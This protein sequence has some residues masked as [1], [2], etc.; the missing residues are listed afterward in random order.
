MLPVAF[1]FITG[2]FPKLSPLICCSKF[3][4]YYYYCCYYNFLFFCYSKP[5]NPHTSKNETSFSEDSLKYI[6]F[7]FQIQTSGKFCMQ[8]TWLRAVPVGSQS[9]S[10]ASRGILLHT[11][12]QKIVIFTGICAAAEFGRGHGG[13]LWHGLLV[14]AVT[15]GKKKKPR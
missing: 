10:I 1:P 14:L 4:Y 2:C 13:A 8:H 15:D 7:I 6:Y 11:A 12:Q 3:N 9:L 5:L